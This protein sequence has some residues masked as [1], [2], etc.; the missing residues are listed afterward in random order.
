MG[1]APYI[2]PHGSGL[3]C[4]SSHIGRIGRRYAARIPRWGAQRPMTNAFIAGLGPLELG[5]ILLIVLVIVG[6][7]RLPQLGR[8]LGGGMREFKDSVTRQGRQA[9]RRR[10]QHRRRP[11][12]ARPSRGR[13]RPAGRRGHARA[14]VASPRR[15]ATL[16]RH[17]HPAEA[18]RARRAPLA[19][20]ASRR[21]AHAHPHLH[22]RARGGRRD[23]PVAGRPDPGDRQ[24]AAGRGARARSRATRRAT[25]SSRARA[26][27]RRRRSST[28]GSRR[29]RSRSPT[30]RRT[31]RRC[32]PGGALS[33]AATAAA[34]ASPRGS[35]RR[36]GHAR[37]S[38]SR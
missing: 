12:G 23:L 16:Q 17:G 21:A 11:G 10:R 32:A 7:K 5:I 28:S 18:H 6:G 26:G 33:R 15:P 25:R 27:R 8:Q 36:P 20:R 30:R 24:R 1:S 34:E 19:R 37:A 31:S 14:L 29:R 13:G 4:D 35:P 2:G 3:E 38:A 9:L 22:R